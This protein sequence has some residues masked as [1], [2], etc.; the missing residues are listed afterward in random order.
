MLTDREPTQYRYLQ[1]VGSKYFGMK[2]VVG[3][4]TDCHVLLEL[5]KYEASR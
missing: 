3:V 1:S 2:L 5:A 4:S